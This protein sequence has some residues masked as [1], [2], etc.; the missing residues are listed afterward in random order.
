MPADRVSA[1]ASTRLESPGW[2]GAP[3]WHEHSRQHHLH[4]CYG[5]PI[6]SGRDDRSIEPVLILAQIAEHLGVSVQAPY[7]LPNKGRGPRGF[8]VGRC[9]HFRVSEVDAWL[10]Q[11]ESEDSNPW[12][13]SVVTKVAT[14]VK[15][16]ASGGGS[17]YGSS[18]SR[19]RQ[20][21]AAQSKL[22][23]QAQAKSEQRSA[24][25]MAEL[26]KQVNPRTGV[27]AWMTTQEK[28]EKYRATDLDDALTDYPGR[29]GPAP[30]DALKSW[31][32]R[33]TGRGRTASARLRQTPHVR[34]R[35][36]SGWPEAGAL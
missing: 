9:L 16:Y 31:K 3:D 11:L 34:L 13:V 23:A 26:W 20:A 8:K 33:A 15:T 10:R 6:E 28:W 22:R 19:A 29:K 21:A 30:A 24:A 7:D 35:S 1:G 27:G 2:T 4:R 18:S 17:S 12:V 32:T 36:P 25:V 14:I 5:R